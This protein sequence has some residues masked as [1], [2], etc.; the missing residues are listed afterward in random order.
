[1]VPFNQAAKAAKKELSAA[2][3]PAIKGIAP[4]RGIPLKSKG[5][6][7]AQQKTNATTAMKAKSRHDLDDQDSLLAT[8]AEKT[9]RV[10]LTRQLKML[11]I[12]INRSVF[13]DQ[14]NSTACP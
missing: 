4:S 10:V 14:G 1:M 7:H 6:N 2:T 8:R 11:T 5:P 9:L 12:Q 3:S 13:L